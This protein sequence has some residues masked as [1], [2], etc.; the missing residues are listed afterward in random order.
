[1]NLKLSDE[2][3]KKDSIIYQEVH[4]GYPVYVFDTDFFKK[5]L[6]VLLYDGENII[7]VP[8][9]IFEYYTKLENTK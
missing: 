1:M 2:R 4:I 6:G 8:E 7:A 3:Y 9:Y 5:V